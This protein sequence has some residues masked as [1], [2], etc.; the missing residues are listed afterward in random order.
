MPRLYLP[1]LW[2]YWVQKLL[3][4]TFDESEMF[5][6]FDRIRDDINTASA[7]GK[8]FWE[9]IP[10]NCFYDEVKDE[11]IYFDQEY[12]WEGESPDI[13]VARAVLALSYS[14]AFTSDPRTRGW[15]AK[16][17]TRYGIADNWEE[18]FQLADIKTRE[19]VFGDGEKALEAMTLLAVDTI[20]E[21]TPLVRRRKRFAPVLAK[22][23]SLGYT[24]PIIYGYGRRGKELLH[25]LVDA[26][27]EITAIIDRENRGLS[28]ISQ[29]P[30][31]AKAD[32]IIVS[33]LDSAEIISE[34]KD[35]TTLPV[36]SL[37]ELV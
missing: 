27:I 21:R 5:K 31:G 2:D 23:Q 37:E 13:A 1:T 8:C 16:L 26:D 6:Q 29:V 30:A 34:L 22:L 32:I 24:R 19:E 25:E 17:K 14:Q 7:T 28:D 12:Y 20:N 4:G 33:I 18:L 36:V 35:K 3:D 10:A 9:F 11:L 15:R